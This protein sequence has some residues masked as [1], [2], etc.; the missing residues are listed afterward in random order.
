MRSAKNNPYGDITVVVPTFNEA[1]SIHRL[2]RGIRSSYKGAS[3]LV[4]DD[5]STDNTKKIVERIAKSD[6]NVRFVDRKAAGRTRGL[7]ASVID[8][9]IA[10][11]TPFVIVMDG[12]LQ[13]PYEMVGKV[14]KS[15]HSNDLVICIRS[16]VEKWPIH[17]KAISK[18]MILMGLA[19]LS[20]RGRRTSKDIMSGFFGVRRELFVKIYKSNPDAFV[21]EGFKVLFDFLK[22][23]DP[24]ISIEEHPYTF[25]DRGSGKSNAKPIH[26]FYLIKS[27]VT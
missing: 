4:M 8:G 23:A 9:V 22:L 5:G 14:A 19:A 7:T 13:H 3:V 17:R 20:I 24:S 6:R 26:A 12:D 18:G 2:I 1:G 21:K 25:K 27:F 15:L 11:K 16:K 10:A